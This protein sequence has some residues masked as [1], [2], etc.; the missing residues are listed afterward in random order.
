MT[1]TAESA[2]HGPGLTDVRMM[3]VAHNS[4]RREIGLSPAAVRAVADGDRR[5]SSQVG[6]HT[7]LWTGMLHHHHTIEDEML[8]DA[9]MQ[10]VPQT[11]APL[12][13]L[14][15]TQ[16]E[17]VAALLDDAE[18]RTRRW[19]ASASAADGAELAVVLDRL[20]HALAEHL[21]TEETRLLPIMAEH[22]TAEEWERFTEAGMGSIPKRLLV[23]GFGMMA[24]EG[25]PEVIAGELAKL[26]ARL[27]V[28]LP[29][30]GRRAMRRYAKRIHGTSA[31]LPRAG[32]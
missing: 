20:A 4:F 6:D 9:L 18:P 14:M 13:S 32:F 11:L 19:R 5:R 7:L 10:R 2:L 25:D 30:L 22:L 26:P 31:P 27:R 21:E 3:V 29:P 17:E 8:W 23:L 16:H 28:L 24:Y 15:Q 12:V 1:H